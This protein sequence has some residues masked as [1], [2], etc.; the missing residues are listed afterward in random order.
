MM[1]ERGGK[2][3]KITGRSK[4]NATHE[5]STVAQTKEMSSLLCAN[6]RVVFIDWKTSCLKR[7][8]H[9][10]KIIKTGP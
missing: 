1:L 8:A 7:G 6:K 4:S 2:R 10:S 3:E 5:K 9:E